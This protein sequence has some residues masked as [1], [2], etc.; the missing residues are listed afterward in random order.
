MKKSHLFIVVCAGLV[1]M[2]PAYSGNRAGA[3]TF[4]LGAGYDY[5]SAKREMDNTGVI[6]VGL[7]YDFTDCWGIEAIVGGFNTNFKRSV[8]DN[9][10][11]NGTLVSVDG[12]YRFLPYQ[13]F[14]PY[15]MAGA[16]VIGLNPN[17]DDA[18]N[19]G[20]INAGLGTELFID[21]SIAFRIE[22]RDFYTLQGGKNDVIVDAGITFLLD[23]C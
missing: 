4:T 10:E 13:F 20:N 2:A 3:A 15:V 6:L 14:E 7:G 17:R 1:S 5:L 16:G 22:G 23:L 12:I 19:E 18:H 11:I 21:Q 9:T 8:H